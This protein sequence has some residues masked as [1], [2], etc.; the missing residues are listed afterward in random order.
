MT[1]IRLAILTAFVLAMAGCGGSGAS[2]PETSASQAEPAAEADTVPAALIEPA[3]LQD[4]PPAEE[5]ALAEERRQA[6]QAI[7]GAEAEDARQQAADM[8]V[9][10]AKLA[11]TSPGRGRTGQPL[12]A[13]RI[14]RPWRGVRRPGRQGAPARLFPGVSRGAQLGAG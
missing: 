13:L 14:G 9:Q 1:Q 3:I 4:D 11:T 5:D 10:E 2:R 8:G 6:E 12:H 7:G